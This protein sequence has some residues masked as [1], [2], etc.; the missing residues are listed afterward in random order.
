MG[1]PTTS[2]RA[3]VIEDS[4]KG[5]AMPFWASKLIE[6]FYAHSL[7]VQRSLSET[8]DR[9]FSE[10]NDLKRSQSQMLSRLSTLEN[11]ILCSS[12][13]ANSQQS[14]LYSTMVKVRADSQRIDEKLKMITWVGIDE[15]IDEEATRRFDRE[16]LKEAVYTSEDTD[17][18]NEFD[19]ARMRTGRQSLTRKFAH[20]FARRDYTAEELKVDR[21][22]RRQASDM[23]ARGGS[24]KA[25]VMDRN[26]IN[27]GKGNADEVRLMIHSILLTVNIA[28]LMINTVALRSPLCSLQVNRANA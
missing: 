18:I 22:L 20:S 2:R 23:N 15:Q 28:H 21:A 11:R 10:L 27:G 8:F 16:I 24:K 7:S 19:A 5:E 4:S 17:L 3:I 9:V 12:S 25:Y 13:S 6:H 26:T 14:I 1:K